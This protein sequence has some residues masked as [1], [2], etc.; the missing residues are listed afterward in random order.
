MKE[1]LEKGLSEPVNTNFIG[2]E[3]LLDNLVLRVNDQ[4]KSRHQSKSNY[5][6]IRL[7]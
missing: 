7:I 3:E 4:I 6:R 2:T 5:I 1:C